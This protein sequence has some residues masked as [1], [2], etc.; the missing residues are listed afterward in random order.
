MN[1]KK[2]LVKTRKNLV[3]PI[4]ILEKINRKIQFRHI[5]KN[6]MLKSKIKYREQG[7]YWKSLTTRIL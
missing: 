2:W 6:N 7:L 4:I 1:F 5:F 3:F